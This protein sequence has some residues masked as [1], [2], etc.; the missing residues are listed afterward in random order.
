MDQYKEQI[1]EK[2]VQ[3]LIE[4]SG[5]PAYTDELLAEISQFVLNNIEPVQT[6]DQLVGF[7]HQ[8]AMKWPIFN[9]ISAAEEGVIQKKV[10]QQ[11]ASDMVTLI[12]QGDFDKAVDTAQSLHPQK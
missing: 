10:E 7:L 2:I 1:K 5:D 11:V 4:V 12:K 8:L 6:Q 3:K 9:G